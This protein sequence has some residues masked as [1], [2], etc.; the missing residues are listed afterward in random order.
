MDYGLRDKV[1]VVVGGG[2]AIAG[3]IASQLAA[4]GACVAVWDVSADAAAGNADA[5]CGAGGRSLAAECDAADPSSVAR[6]LDATVARFG[7]VDILV[8]GAG[9]SSP[10][11]AT[12]DERKFF[13]I[14]LDALNDMWSANYLT[15]VVPSQA[16]GRVF[17]EKGRGVI[18]NISSVAG[19]L[20]LTR[21]VGYS[22][23]K[24]A[25]SSFTRWLAVYM[26]TTCSPRIRVNALAPGFVLT[27]LN[28]FL[29]VDQATGQ[30]TQRGHTIISQVPM[31][32]Y[33]EPAEIA[34]V[35]LFLV[36]DLAS[37]ITGAV[38]PVDGGFTAFAGV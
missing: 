37:F 27:E 26:A 35:A 10:S 19:E 11:C 18:L 20:P 3:E 2:G 8:N 28:R 31:R 34:A 30:P 36:S 15:A 1:A 13:D 14:G 21:V 32:R 4:E 25:V 22:N 38:I 6:A 16:V 17:A 24:A 7:T 33:G 23:S 12:S 5:I 29:L 9:G